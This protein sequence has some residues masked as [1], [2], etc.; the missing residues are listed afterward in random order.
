MGKM[1]YES[2]TGGVDLPLAV[3]ETEERFNKLK[4]D[5][6]ALQAVP[7]LRRY[8]DTI[9]GIGVTV[10][11][12]RVSQTEALAFLLPFANK[13]G[14]HNLLRADFIRQTLF[15]ANI[16][17]R[18]KVPLPL[19][20]L[21]SPSIGSSLRIDPH[22]NGSNLVADSLE[23]A[24]DS[25]ANTI[26]RWG[27]SIVG[28]LGGSQGGT[29]ALKA[30]K[31]FGGNPMR[32]VA[33]ADPIGTFKT[34]K[35]DL[36]RRFSSDGANLRPTVRDAGIL[37]YSDA[38][39]YMSGDGIRSSVESRLRDGKF[40]AN[41]LAHP[42]Q[43]FE[44]F[45]AMTDQTFPVDVRTA[46]TS[47]GQEGALPVVIGFGNN[48][49]MVDREQLIQTAENAPLQTSQPTNLHVVEVAGTHTWMDNLPLFASFA[50]YAYQQT[51]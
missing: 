12:G 27:V 48:S 38:M 26:S 31:H 15:R 23:R 47:R 16:T 45:A 20:V 9:S 49:P 4:T 19:I 42:R 2:W 14:R 22:R 32:V 37:P 11:G 28:L 35:A 33:A 13:V 25:Y 44:L 46:I 17:D 21:S 3:Q 39:G 7:I 24:V 10:L 40:A 43:N 18:Y 41:V 30:P 29:L 36:F 34:S 1:T 51:T 6:A 8:R 5:R 50:L